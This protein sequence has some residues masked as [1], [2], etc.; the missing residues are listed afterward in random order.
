MDNFAAN[1]KEVNDLIDVD[2]EYLKE[3]DA[4]IGENGLNVVCDVCHHP[5]HNLCNGADCEKG[6]CWKDG[7]EYADDE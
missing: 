7:E 4:E 2:I 3:K 6:E 1:L 5:V